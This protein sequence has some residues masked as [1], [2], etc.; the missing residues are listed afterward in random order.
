MSDR[1][2]E[3]EAGARV[4]DAAAAYREALLAYRRAHSRETSH[5]LL[6]ARQ[7]LLAA[8]AAPEAAE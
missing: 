6:D 7:A 4:L 1:S 5:A 8:A 2:I 3:C